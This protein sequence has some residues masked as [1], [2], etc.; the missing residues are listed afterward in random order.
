MPSTFLLVVCVA[1]FALT[2][3][4]VASGGLVA[5][6]DPHVA[7]WAYLHLGPDRGWLSDVTRL[8]DAALLAV[9]A[10]VAAAWLAR[11]GRVR[12]GVLL[13][14]AAGA[15]ALVTTV[16]KDA[17]GRARPPYVD[18]VEGPHSFSFPSGHASGAF[19]VYVLV[20]FLLAERRP[21]GARALALAAS[22]LLATF[23]AV[24]RVLLPVH[25][26]TDVI[27]GA[28]VGLSVAVVAVIARAPLR[29]RS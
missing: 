3:V 11:S 26:T 24:T 17:F 23:V 19:A 14:A 25:Y 16:L 5:R 2:A 12:D 28:A 21:P 15:T 4:D 7:D 27:A 9:V 1:V 22:V 18:P 6:A 8:G 13:L 29:T 20:A 10:L